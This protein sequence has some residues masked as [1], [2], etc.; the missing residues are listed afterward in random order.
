MR[1]LATYDARDS[2]SIIVTANIL[3]V[4][5]QQPNAEAMWIK[6]GDVQ[7][8]GSLA[9]VEA[10]AKAANEDVRHEDY[11]DKTIVPRLY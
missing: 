1:K 11:G 2:Q 4:N 8:I 6:N 3:T 5:D 10:A 7:A 9:E